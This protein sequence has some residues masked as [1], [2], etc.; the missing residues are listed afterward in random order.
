MLKEQ[1]Q[2]SFDASACFFVSLSNSKT[3]STFT[4]IVRGVVMSSPCVYFDI[5]I[6]TLK[7]IFIEKKLFFAE[8]APQKRGWKVF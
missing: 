2:K 6:P 8:K 4:G 1:I 3:V 5:S 7:N